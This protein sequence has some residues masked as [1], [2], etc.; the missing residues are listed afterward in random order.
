MTKFMLSIVVFI[1]RTTLDYSIMNIASPFGLWMPV[2]TNQFE[3]FGA[4][5]YTN[6]YNPAQRQQFYLFS[7]P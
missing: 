5:S 7:L 1:G 6:I 3:R 2:L 4:F